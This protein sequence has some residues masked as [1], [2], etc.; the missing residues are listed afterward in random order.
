MKNV[1]FRDLFMK[2]IFSTRTKIK[3]YTCFVPLGPHSVGIQ[4]DSGGI[5]KHEPAQ[6]AR[7]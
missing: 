2:K 6:A 3:K 4:E 7:G 5:G 1:F